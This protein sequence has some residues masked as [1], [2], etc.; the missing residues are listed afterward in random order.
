MTVD[1]V[2][3]EI[4][5]NVSPAGELVFYFLGA[6][7]L[8]CFGYGMYRH[9]K[10]ILSGKPTPL[11]WPTIRAAL[12]KRVVTILLNVSVV[13]RHR[14]A[15]V[16]HLAIM[17]G[18]AALFVGT[19][20]VA[21]EYDVFQKI[22]GR[23]QGF[24]A[25]SFFLGYELALDTL[26]ALFCAGLLAAL[27]RRYVL[28]RPP[29]TREPA[30]LLLS[31]WLLLIGLTGFLV[32]GMRLAGTS[33]PLP[34]SPRWSPVGLAISGLWAHVGAG[35]VQAW[36][37]YGWWFH[38][39]LAL[40]W[41]AA[42]PRA[43]K[44]LHLLTAGVNVLLRDLRPRGRLAPID[45]EAAFESGLPV[46]VSTIADLT[47]K[48]LLD[49]ASCTECGRCETACPAHSSGKALSPRAIVLKLRDQAGREMPLFG[50]GEPRGRIMDSTIGPEEIWACTT[51]LACVEACPVGIDPLAKILEL[52]R[53]EVM[54]DDRYPETF[55]DVFTGL[56]K[57]GNP[58]NQHP[59]SRLDWARGLSVRTMAEVKA[60]GETVEYL[61]WV[62]CSAAFEPRN[63][64][65][66][67][68]LV[69]ILEKAQVSF[70]VLGEEESCT[71]DPARRMG[72]EF[73]FQI[74]AQRNVETF[75]PYAF[76][77]I[78]TL[79]PHCF[80]CLGTEYP[81]FGGSYTVVH[82]TQLIRELL[83]DGKLKLSTALRGTVAYHDSCYL[84]RHHGEFDAPREVLRNIP[85]LEIVEM[86]QSRE[87]GM[88]CGA[89]GGL[90]WIEEE[91]GRR[92]NERRVDQL[93]AALGT[94]QVAG[95]PGVLAT[96]CP[97]CM[98]MM[99][100]GLASRQAPVQD[101][102]IAELVAEAAGLSV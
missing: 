84:G 7:S 22:L 38:A 86:T 76:R 80:H 40:G 49:L 96:A 61:L 20:L 37:L 70:A 85:G 28:K 94:G 100:D 65:I 90:M 99:E 31:G 12:A 39:V 33:H 67:R 88:C 32:E 15:G 60:A 72:N 46:G 95:Q 57:R 41:I 63:Q 19:V 91:P 77:R 98:T 51:C 35:T 14:F 82:H 66:A 27:V 30:D 4:F 34:Y 64:R 11:S 52:R 24:F 59:S 79:C 83:R 89:G 93:Q 54:S 10:R 81:D 26:G 50:R 55:G 44:V 48:D 92:V 58:W 97:F 56:K 101:K 71:G 25:G 36:H 69:R 9:L 21:I 73:L 1:P 62:G 13:R 42:L 45:I 6:L 3:R 17:W 74:Q 18:F 75:K 8:G 29:L 16:M 53:N 102:D 43:P 23:T 78:L 5:W 2:T 68:S 87:T 47:R